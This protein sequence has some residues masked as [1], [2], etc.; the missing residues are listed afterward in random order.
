MK[1]RVKAIMITM[2]LDDNYVH[3]VQMWFDNENDNDDDDDDDNDD[4]EC[5]SQDDDDILNGKEKCFFFFCPFFSCFFNMVCIV[6]VV[7]SFPCSLSLQTKYCR[8]SRLLFQH[9]MAALKRF[10]GF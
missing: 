8:V 1:T 7:L 6:V 2:T 5:D 10:Q 3:S 9:M 4:S